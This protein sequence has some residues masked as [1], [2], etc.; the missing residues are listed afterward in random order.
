MD[1]NLVATDAATQLRIEDPAVD[2]SIARSLACY[3]ALAE[4]S[5]SV[6]FRA[7]LQ[8]NLT[9]IPLLL[10]LPPV[11]EEI[12]LNRRWLALVHPDDRPEAAAAWARAVTS[13]NQ[14]RAEF[15]ILMQ[16]GRY[17]WHQATG[18]RITGEDGTPQEWI[19]ACVDIHHRTSRQRTLRLLDSFTSRTR[20]MRSFEEVVVCGQNLI[21]ETL[22]ASRVVYG[23][24]IEGGRSFATV[25]N[26]CVDCV[27]LKGKYPLTGYS[28]QISQRLRLGKLVAC[29]DLDDLDES[30]DVKRVLKECGIQAMITCPLMKEGQVVAILGVHQTVPREWSSDEVEMVQ[31][32][33][34]RLW[35]EAKRVK[36]EHDLLVS[37]HRLRS[38]LEAATVGVVVNDNKGVFSYA[39][40]PF[41]RIL[42][43]SA[44]E[45]EAG[46]VTW[47]RI[48]SPE[49][50]ASDYESFKQLLRSRT[51][52]PYE[53]V[54]VRK[55]GS[56]VHV[57]VGATLVPDE[58]GSG[59]LGAAFVTDLTQ[60]KAVEAE[61]R[62]LNVELENRV[63]ERTAELLFANREMEG[64]TYSVSHD[65]RSPLR[66]IVA[67][68]RIL[69]EDVADKLNEQER[70]LLEQQARS[71]TKLGVLIDDLLKLSRLSREEVS[72]TRFDISGL[73]HRVFDELLSNEWRTSHEIVI[74]PEMQAHGDVRHIQLL[75]LNLFDNACKFSPGGG[76]I[77]FGQ[78]EGVFFVKDS[79]IGFDMAY[80]PKLFVPFE[81][82]VREADFPGTGVG[83]AN[84][85]RIVQR[86]G[87]KIWA[88]ST[89]NQ[90]ATFYFTLPE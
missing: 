60:L 43:Y 31:S 35:S 49:R 23:E 84:V 51:C 82:L 12:A 25:P 38:I 71:A 62:S 53:T 28:S 18:V 36:A 89:P 10:G 19:G 22:A 13:G 39:N 65:L 87:G 80:A 54:L 3:K 52:E 15:R 26:Y 6:I 1:G 47:S 34:D 66:S 58:T 57:Y 72:K 69:L 86:H 79:G 81:R 50:M 63:E 29:D 30:D 75:L 33:A 61:L 77:H 40:A 37:S 27:D 56:R 74:E 70:A 85:Q 68:S 64:F 11:H 90:G 8:G 24:A 2:Q 9:E 67:A 32:M 73:A 48:Q 78:S 42:G 5:A 59:M 21:G 16:N 14:Y 45:I 88:E 4:V 76:Q 17:R 46:E 20:E 55:D 44:A 83:L 41:L 7:D